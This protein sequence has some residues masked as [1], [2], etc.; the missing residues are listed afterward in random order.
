MNL[1]CCH[2]VTSD[3][4]WV[5]TS[6]SQL[7]DVGVGVGL[8]CF[9]LFCLFFPLALCQTY[10]T[11]QQ[12]KNKN[13]DPAFA[14]DGWNRKLISLIFYLELKSW[15]PY[16]GTA[17]RVCYR[18]PCQTFAV[19]RCFTATSSA[20]PTSSISQ[21]YKLPLYSVFCSRN[22]MGVPSCATLPK[23]FTGHINT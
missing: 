12:W 17:N 16:K 19:P 7:Q 14:F 6:A 3:W 4:Y 20:N 21:G 15:H 9:C 11:R 18:Q 23:C 1:W 10:S 2:L 22:V 5:A 8:W 13:P